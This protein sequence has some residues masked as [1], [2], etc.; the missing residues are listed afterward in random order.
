MKERSLVQLLAALTA[1]LLLVIGVLGF[2][3]D[4][5]L[6]GTFEVS[7]RVNVVHLVLGVVGLASAWSAENAHAFLV[8]GGAVYLALWVLGV[9]GGGHWIRVNPADNWLHFLLGV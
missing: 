2:L 3:A 8:G 9:A 6:L 1:V 7:T 5:K 4:T